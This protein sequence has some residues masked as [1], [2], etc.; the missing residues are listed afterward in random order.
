MITYLTHNQI[1]KQRWD[2]CIK[3]SPN[4]NVYAL[5]WYLDIVHPRWEA[6]VEDDYVSVLPLTGNRKCGISYLFQPFFVQ[7][8]GVFSKEDITTDKIQHFI[9]VIPE[10]FRF[11]EIRLNSGNI[12]PQGSENIDNHRNIELDLSSDYSILTKNYSSNTKRDIAKAKAA[13]LTMADDVEPAEIVGL[14]RK[15]KGKDVVHWGDEEYARFL[16]LV[17]EA[18]K[19]G[20]CFVKGAKNTDNQLVA[21][22]VFMTGHNRIVFLFSGADESNKELH[23]LSYIIDSVICKFSGTNVTLDFE[24]S[25]NDGLARFYMGFGGHEVCYPG[26]RFNKTRGIFKLALKIFKNK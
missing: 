13:G 4:G 11:A 10:K 21:G 20:H 24:G 26:L 17:Q 15:N 9:D 19:R 3:Q 7:Q 18:T 5:S 16:R 12:F 2:D 14:F 23:A 8:L 22:A 6:L 1:D 25:D